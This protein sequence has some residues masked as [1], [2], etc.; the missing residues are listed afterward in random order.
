MALG[1]TTRASDSGWVD[2]VWTCASGSVT[3]MTSVATACWGLVFWQYDGRPY[4]SVSGPETG[5]GVAPVPAGAAFVGIEFA[6]GTSLRALPAPALVDRGAT[7]PDVTRR[8]FRLAGDRWETPGPD[9]AEALVERLV[10]A[11]AVVRDPFVAELRRGHHPFAS[12]RTLERRFRAATGLTQGAVRQ[13][14]R[15]REAAVLLAAGVA[16]AEAVTRLGYADEPHLARALRRYVGRTAGQ[17]RAG[18][19]RPIALDLGQRTTS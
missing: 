16:V 18:G 10:R 5:A 11:G 4:A 9:D 17:L 13:I 3:E 1:F 6:V 12:P 7:L 19:G 2:T 8:T 15:A 14:E